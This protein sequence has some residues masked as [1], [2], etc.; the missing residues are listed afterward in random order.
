ML[1]RLPSLAIALALLATTTTSAADIAGTW[2][3]MSDSVEVSLN[4]GEDYA[5][6]QFRQVRGQQTI[7]C[8]YLVD[9]NNSD[10]DALHSS[11]NELASFTNS[12]FCADRMKFGWNQSG[13]QLAATMTLG[14]LTEEVM[15]DRQTAAPG[16]PT[17]AGP[18]VDIAGL[19]FGQSPDTVDSVLSAMPGVERLSFTTGFDH[20]DRFFRYDVASLTPDAAA[21]AEACDISGSSG[22]TIEDTY[23]TISAATSSEEMGV[24]A[25]RRHFAPLLT[26]PPPVNALEKAI[27]AKYGEPTTPGRWVF[28]SNGLLFNSE[29]IDEGGRSPTHYAVTRD[30]KGEIVSKLEEPVRICRTGDQ[31]F[32][33]PTVS[34]QYACRNDTFA[35][36]EARIDRGGT[37]MSIAVD[38]QCGAVLEIDISRNGDYVDYVTFNALDFVGARNAMAAVTAD[39][40]DAIVGSDYRRLAVASD[41]EIKL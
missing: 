18:V 17:S 24:I 25:I 4:A 29:R 5:L 14:N 15:L 11:A 22:E 2:Y 9:L 39:R 36:P 26:N 1:I 12:E 28:D 37:T 23:L 41:I 31:R 34:G 35:Y 32:S 13:E 27:T 20:S 21:Y 8:T 16:A 3:A 6:L 33:L 38:P 30:D 40:I 19:N 7:G 10:A